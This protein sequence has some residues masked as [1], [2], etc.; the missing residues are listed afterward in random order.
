M[1]IDTSSLPLPERVPPLRDEAVADAAH[2]AFVRRLEQTAEG[3]R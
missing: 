2:A 3:G 1:S